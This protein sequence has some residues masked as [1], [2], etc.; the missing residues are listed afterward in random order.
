MPPRVND[1]YKFTEAPLPELVETPELPT[2]ADCRRFVTT[3]RTFIA[4]GDATV[5]T[6]R[7]GNTQYTKSSVFLD[8]GIVEAKI[9]D[10]RDDDQSPYEPYGIEVRLDIRDEDGSDKWRHLLIGIDFSNEQLSGWRLSKTLHRKAD[11]ALP[12]NCGNFVEA[13]RF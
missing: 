3:A 6:N 9:V 10:L 12:E 7:D 8:D 5:T 4:S 2:Q 11:K 1:V 13:P